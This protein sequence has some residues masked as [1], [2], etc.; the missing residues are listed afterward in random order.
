MPETTA[1]KLITKEKKMSSQFSLKTFLRKTPYSLVKN[2]FE[3]KKLLK[4]YDWGTQLDLEQLTAAISAI[5]DAGELALCDFER[6]HD[7]AN[8]AGTS[9]LIEQSRSPIHKLDIATQ[10]AEMSSHHERAMFVFLHHPMLFHWTSE[11]VYIDS[12]TT[13]S[14]K[15]CIVGADLQYSDSTEIRQ[16]LGAAIAEY[17]HQ[18]GRGKYCLVDYY[19]RI[20]PD[21]HCFFAYPENYA[22][23]D[24]VYEDRNKL[25]R[26]I[27]R[28][29]M[30]VIFVYNPAN[31][32][33]Y[34]HARG[35]KFAKA[36]QEI[37][38]KQVLELNGIPDENT[39]VYDLAILKEANFR[40]VTDPADNIE[41]VMLKGVELHLPGLLRK[42]ITVEADAAPG[43]E[44][45]VFDM[46]NKTMQAFAV[47][48]AATYIKRAKIT[49]KFRSNA[50]RRGKGVTFFVAS[51]NGCTL[52]D[53]PHHNVIK[54]YMDK[55]GFVK[56]LLAQEDAA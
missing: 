50:G 20:S 13:S 36:L 19:F 32:M 24:L 55:W 44:R 39:K 54:R 43:A 8:E 56:N 3:S 37:F 27:R 7:L 41:S 49:V 17:Y 15:V 31:G 1:G 48:S 2:Y 5:G 46:M 34:V 30:E 35:D 21:R 33:L 25:T 28:P 4:D 52:N 10:L 6:V 40:F 42:K 12:L 38:C 51:P 11:M 23:E 9:Q 22:T 18:Q 45:T 26:R 53:V 47:T 14:W 29:V 16:K